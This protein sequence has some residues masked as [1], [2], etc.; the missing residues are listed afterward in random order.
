MR[1]YVSVS[2][3]A[4]CLVMV[5]PSSVMLVLLLFSGAFSRVIIDPGAHADVLSAHPPPLCMCLF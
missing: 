3:V 5:T 2:R 4:S 1:L